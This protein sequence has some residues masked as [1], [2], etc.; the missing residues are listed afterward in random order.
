MKEWSVGA[1]VVE[2]WWRSEGFRGLLA[3]EWGR[4]RSVGF[5]LLLFFHFK[6]KVSWGTDQPSTS[7]VRWKDQGTVRIGG[8]GL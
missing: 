3:F 4:T 6:I 8:E 1:L 7:S 5:C 2:F